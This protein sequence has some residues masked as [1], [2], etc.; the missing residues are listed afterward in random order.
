[1]IKDILTYF[2]ILFFTTA[3]ALTARAAVIELSKPDLTIE[4]A[5]CASLEP[6]HG[7][8]RCFHIRKGER[9]DV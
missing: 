7:H 6:W 4:S 3:L 1:M 2:W 8:T 5:G 9:R